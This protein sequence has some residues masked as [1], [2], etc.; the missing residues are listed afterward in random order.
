MF[1]YINNASCYSYLNA[2][3]GSRFDAF[4]AGYQPKNVFVSISLSKFKKLKIINIKIVLLQ[5]INNKLEHVE[6]EIQE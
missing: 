2:V 3:I 5:I 1:V 6:T 4:F